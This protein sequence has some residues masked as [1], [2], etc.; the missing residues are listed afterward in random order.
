MFLFLYIFL[1]SYSI[2][3]SAQI[4]QRAEPIPS[5]LAVEPAKYI[6]KSLKPLV[7]EIRKLV[8]LNSQ[9]STLQLQEYFNTLALPQRLK[10]KLINFFIVKISNLKINYE[11]DLFVSTL[12]S[13][14]Y[15]LF[16]FI[17]LLQVLGIKIDSDFLDPWVVEKIL[18][19]QKT[20]FPCEDTTKNLTEVIENNFQL[21]KIWKSRVKGDS[22]DAIDI[23]M[24]EA[25]A[26]YFY[27][28]SLFRLYLKILND[29]IFIEFLKERGEDRRYFYTEHKKA[30][31]LYNYVSLL[32]NEAAKFDD[33][34]LE[35]DPKTYSN[36]SYYKLIE[37]YNIYRLLV[38]SVLCQREL[39][40]KNLYYHEPQN[41][42]WSFISHAP[43][44][45]FLFSI[46]TLSSTPLI[47][48]LGAPNLPL[49]GV[50]LSLVPFDSTIGTLI[51][52]RTHDIHH[53]RNIVNMI[54][55]SDEF[56]KYYTRNYLESIKKVFLKF[57]SFCDKNFTPDEI[58]ILL[59]SVL[60]FH[61]EKFEDS[62]PISRNF[63]PRLL[64]F[65]NNRVFKPHLDLN[66]SP[67]RQKSIIKNWYK[68]WS[69]FPL[70]TELIDGSFKEVIIEVFI[71]LFRGY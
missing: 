53:H 22:D 67:E 64:S 31:S 23:P 38:D 4:T 5:L 20:H 68:T 51:A 21:Y 47:M 44:R 70:R 17:D 2:E 60:D 13:K 19:Y 37:M 59:K 15:A 58:T 66:L 8:L 35:D 56:Y 3:I 33:L 34:V 12:L 30:D 71:R 6:A 32:L 69:T 18:L 27:Y 9:D 65:H 43:H 28:R 41:R 25:I 24:P 7:N 48:T 40:P 49:L 10:N 14:V 57:L 63:I 16:D 55:Y 39:L 46:G 1:F 54:F 50:S 61:H 26:V 36:L 42:L 62:L 52:R 11:I 45:F 29:D